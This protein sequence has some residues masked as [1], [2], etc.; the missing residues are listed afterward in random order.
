MRYSDTSRRA[1]QAC[2]CLGLKL[3]PYSSHDSRG[4]AVRINN[5]RFHHL[6]VILG[7][8]DPPGPIHWKA[9][10]PHRTFQRRSPMVSKS[11]FRMVAFAQPSQTQP[12]SSAVPQ[13]TD[14]VLAFPTNR[15]T[16]GSLLLGASGIQQKMS[17]TG[18]SR[19]KHHALKGTLY[20]KGSL[21]EA[22][23]ELRRFFSRQ[24]RGLASLDKKI[25]DM[26]EAHRRGR[27]EQDEKRQKE[28]RQI[29]ARRI[30]E[31]NELRAHLQALEDVEVRRQIRNTKVRN[32]VKKS[33]AWLVFLGVPVC[34]AVAA[35]RF[36]TGEN[37]LQRLVSLW[38]ILAFSPLLS[39]FL[40]KIMILRQER[41]REVFSIWHE[42]KGL[43]D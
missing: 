17:S 38:P 11:G 8:S 21:D 1:V 32:I 5:Y 40:I 36:G 10:T 4:I 15:L 34:S 41:L 16:A 42:V 28:M 13:Y 14:P 25:C 3:M 7:I 22:V 2:S 20:P 23:Y 31:L 18:V 12:P 19:I 33:V 29:L 35:N 27:S 39:A 6:P 24:S 37:V 9:P 43:F 30:E 26:Q